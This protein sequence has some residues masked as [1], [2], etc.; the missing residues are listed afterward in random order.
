[1][2]S[3]TYHQT[4]KTLIAVNWPISQISPMQCFYRLQNH[5]WIWIYHR[6]ANYGR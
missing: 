1:L 5:I 3:H 6:T 2:I 4:G